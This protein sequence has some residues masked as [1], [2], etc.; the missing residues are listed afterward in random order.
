MMFAYDRSIDIQLEGIRIR[1][2]RLRPSHSSKSPIH[3]ED[4]SMGVIGLLGLLSFLVLL[5]LLEPLDFTLGIK[6][7]SGATSHWS[8]VLGGSGASLR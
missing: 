2:H 5:L 3:T 1:M 7:S 6:G 8:A 4:S